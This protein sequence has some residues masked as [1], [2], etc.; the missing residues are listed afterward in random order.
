MLEAETINDP[1]PLLLLDATDKLLS[2]YAHLVSEALLKGDCVDLPVDKD[3]VLR[4]L[5]PEIDLTDEILSVFLI[6]PKPEHFDSTQLES[7]LLDSIRIHLP[8]ILVDWLHHTLVERSREH[9]DLWHALANLGKVVDKPLNTPVIWLLD[10]N[11]VSFVENN[12]LELAQ[13]DR[14]PLVDPVL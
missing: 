2:S 10:E 7:L 1:I 14:S 5:E 12:E 8:E 9:R 6:D 4:E 3:H 11:L 13:I